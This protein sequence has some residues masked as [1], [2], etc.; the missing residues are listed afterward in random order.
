MRNIR[1]QAQRSLVAKKINVAGGFEAIGLLLRPAEPRLATHP[2]PG[3]SLQGLDNPNQLGGGDNAL[4]ERIAWGKIENA[5][6]AL[7][8]AKDG[9][10]NIGVGQVSFDPRLSGRGTHMKV[11]SVDGVEQ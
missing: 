10:K 11:P 9:F 4:L 1:G 3:A 5:E 8:R 7:C 6:C 2:D